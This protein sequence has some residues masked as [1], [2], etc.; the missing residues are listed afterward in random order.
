MSLPTVTYLTFDSVSEG[1]GASQIVPYME[2]L[3]QRGV[4]V[5]LHSFEKKTIDA[6]TTRRLQT[7]GVRWLPHRFVHGGSAAGALRVAHG[8]A[9]VRDAELVHARSDLPAASALVARRRHWVWD[10]RSFWA[11]E[12][13]A[14]RSLQAGSVQERV[15]RHIERRAAER[16]TAIVVLASAAADVL[17]KRFGSMLHKK[18]EVI[19]TCVELSRFEFAPLPDQGVLRL[20]FSGTLNAYYDLPT[21]LRL[22]QKLQQRRPV[23]LRVLT[24]GATAWEGQLAAAGVERQA[25]K[26]S[27]MAAR[28][29]DS[30]VGLSICRLD[31]GVSLA[32]KMP[33]KIAEFLACG[34]PVVVNRGLG[35]FDDLLPA[36]RAGVVVGD[37]SDHGLDQA[38]ALLEMLIE[39]RDT[40]RRCRA[41]A[42]QHFS[43]DVGVD[44]LL[45]AYERAGY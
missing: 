41:L 43:V 7:C 33:T 17:A 40:P 19:P 44:K 1:V 13:I 11:D 3:A 8:A 21:M 15:L 30:H 14:M 29:A 16:S 10:V 20:M 31:A 9:L 24:P 38:A 25:A 12:R 32:A 34:R 36:F 39:D 42:E 27:E 23:R 6:V 37:L 22:V 35:D 26:P 18:T 2:R 28:L 5:V 4:D 45:R